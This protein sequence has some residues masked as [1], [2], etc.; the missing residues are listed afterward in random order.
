MSKVDHRPDRREGELSL[1]VAG[2]SF[3]RQW[4]LAAGALVRFTSS[5]RRKASVAISPSRESVSSSA[6]DVPSHTDGAV[7]TSRELENKPRLVISY[8]TAAQ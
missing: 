8:T 3:D 6:S 7:A 4:H 5:P 1:Q 2:G